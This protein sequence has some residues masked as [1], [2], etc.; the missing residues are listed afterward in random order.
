MFNIKTFLRTKMCCALC[1]C[2]RLSD[3][4]AYLNTCPLT[5]S[6]RLAI[7]FQVSEILT[8]C[9]CGDVAGRFT[10]ATDQ[11]QMRLWNTANSSSNRPFTIHL[12]GHIDHQSTMFKRYRR[13]VTP[14]TWWGIQ[15]HFQHTPSKTRG[16]EILL[17]LILMTWRKV[18]WTAF[19]RNST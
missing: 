4:T 9:F 5:R 3:F 18:Y 8:D 11:Q 17:R 2:F 19:H 14:T 15:T 10:T 12:D 16:T 6:M 1:W 13:S 7:V